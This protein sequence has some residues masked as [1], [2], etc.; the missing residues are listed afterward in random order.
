MTAQGPRVGKWLY[1]RASA[2]FLLVASYLLTD[3]KVKVSA[4]KSLT[5]TGCLFIPLAFLPRD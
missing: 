1:C 4:P 2:P 3:L 5:N